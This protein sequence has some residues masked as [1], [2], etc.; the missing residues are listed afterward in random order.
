MQGYLWSIANPEVD[1]CFKTEP[2][3]GLGGRALNYP[4]GK[5]LGGSSSINGMIYM[6]GQAADY[7]EVW[8]P[9][10]QG[11]GGWS[12]K[13]VLPYFVRSED[14]HDP[15]A[16][17]GKVHGRG[18]EWRVEKQR[19]SWEILDRFQDAAAE[20]G[21]PKVKDFNSGD[22]FG[23]R[24]GRVHL[25]AWWIGVSTYAMLC[26]AGVKSLHLASPTHSPID[27]DPAAAATSR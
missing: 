25:H 14:H 26:V 4:R 22:N 9:A 7:D 12:W 15:A 16:A 23:S 1:W 17:D 8:A 21:I 27:I 11:Q 13:E 19:L 10:L 2:V 18:G 3:P 24:Y 20:H 5:V 6:R